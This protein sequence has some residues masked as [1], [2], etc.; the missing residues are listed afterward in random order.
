MHRKGGEDEEKEKQKFEQKQSP[1]SFSAS[2]RSIIT[3]F[4]LFFIASQYVIN[5]CCILRYFAPPVSQLHSYFGVYISNG[6]NFMWKMVWSEDDMFTRL[7]SFLPK[8]CFLPQPQDVLLCVCVW[9]LEGRVFSIWLR[10]CMY[11]SFFFFN[12]LLIKFITYC[13]MRIHIYLNLSSW[14]DMTYQTHHTLHPNNF[15]FVSL[16]LLLFF[17]PFNWK[18]NMRWK[19]N[20]ESTRL[21]VSCT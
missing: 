20:F 11:M 6:I 18:I 13:V 4:S 15:L 17:I 10:E 12:F 16:L 21:R 14:N 8:L 19:L 2:H 1:Y 3:L 7:P 9:K 5:P